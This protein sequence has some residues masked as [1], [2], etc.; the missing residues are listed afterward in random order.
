MMVMNGS[1]GEQSAEGQ[2]ADESMQPQQGGGGP[3]SGIDNYD[4]HDEDI[5]EDDEFKEYKDDEEVEEVEQQ[6]VGDVPGPLVFAMSLLLCA[7]IVCKVLEAF[8]LV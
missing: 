5:G 1:S 2:I 4:E 3:D 6:E 8:A 7:A